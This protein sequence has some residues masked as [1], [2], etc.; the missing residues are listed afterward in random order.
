MAKI[1]KQNQAAVPQKV[2]HEL[3]DYNSETGKWV[4]E[5]NRGT[6]ARKGQPAGYLNKKGYV[7]IGI[8]GI[9]YLAHRLAWA[10]VYGDYPEGEQPLIDHING[11]RGDNR[12]ANLKISSHGENNRNKKMRSTNTSSVN[13][14]FRREMW[15]GSKTKKNWYWIAHWYDE[16]GK[17][18]QKHFS[19]SIYGEDRAKQMATD[20]RE[21]QIRRL[22]V[23]FGIL[24]SGRHGV[25]Q[26]Q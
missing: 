7:V 18:R 12:I 6:R 24:Y 16:N 21:E 20:C 26:Y 10:Y 23:N 2:L 14:V 19:I 17:F 9:G 4:N 3:F 8:N 25:H 13:G 22:E 15:N 11:K 5:T 1:N